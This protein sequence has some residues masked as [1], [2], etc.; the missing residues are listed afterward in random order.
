M[1]CNDKIVKFIISSFINSSINLPYLNM[2]TLV[3][4]KMVTL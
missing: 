4:P 1:F 2:S 3:I